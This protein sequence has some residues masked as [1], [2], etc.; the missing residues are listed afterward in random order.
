MVV[1]AP[2]GFLNEPVLELLQVCLSPTL[3]SFDL[4]LMI[5]YTSFVDTRR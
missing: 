5:V 2:R 4:L 1:T 3:F